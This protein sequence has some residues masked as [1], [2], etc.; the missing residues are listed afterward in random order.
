[1]QLLRNLWL[2]LAVHQLAAPSAS[3]VWRSA[4]GQVAIHT[5]L[6]LVGLDHGSSE[7]VAERLKVSVLLEGWSVCVC[8]C[9][10]SFGLECV[11]VRAF[12]LEC[13]FVC[14][15]VSVSVCVC[16]CGQVAIHTPLL[17]V[18]L[19]HGSS[20]DVAERLKV[21]VLFEGWGVCVCV[22][23]CMCVYVCVCARSFGLEC[24][25]VC[26]RVCVVVC[27]C[28]CVCLCVCVCVCARAFGLECV[29][30]RAFGL[31]CVCAFG[32]ECVCAVV[33]MGVCMCA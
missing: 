11:C 28:E 20:E 16:V 2:H 30:V 12:G 26:V 24:V 3:P 18:G 33:S 1:V 7:D 32:L 22:C 15:C 8:V 27:A 13:V 6:L 4:A 21:C 10:R 5:P 9:A 23:V 19:D 31:D 17:L 29:C 25:F 14:V